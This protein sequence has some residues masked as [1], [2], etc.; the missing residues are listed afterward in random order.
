MLNDGRFRSL[1]KDADVYMLFRL[2]LAPRKYGQKQNTTEK[3]H[4]Y[5]LKCQMMVVR[6]SQSSARVRETR[7][8]TGGEFM[9]GSSIQLIIGSA[10][11]IEGRIVREALG[12]SKDGVNRMTRSRGRRKVLKNVVLDAEMVAFSDRTD[13]IDGGLSLASPSFIHAL[14]WGLP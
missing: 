2:S 8:W 5:M 6:E 10:I 3:E 7:P 11:D 4:R 13:S 1:L 9:G 12:L 14:I